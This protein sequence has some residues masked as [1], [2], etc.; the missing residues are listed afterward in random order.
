MQ[1]VA[2][3]RAKYYKIMFFGSRP[4]KLLRNVLLDHGGLDILME[5]LEKKTN[6]VDLFSNAVL[7][8]KILSE[9][10]GIVSPG[11]ACNV[12]G[13]GGRGIAQR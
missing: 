13:G 10:V 11:K 6:D 3:A 2:K 5:V 1:L 7:S 9:H 12:W 8:L 4:R